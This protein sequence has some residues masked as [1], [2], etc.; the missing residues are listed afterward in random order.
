MV[1]L[2]DPLIWVLLLPA[3]AAS[4]VLVQMVLGLFTCCGTF[5]LRGRSVPLRWW[6]IPLGAAI[7]GLLWTAVVLYTLLSPQGRA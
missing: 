5:R 2:G 1:R 3:L 4:G 6:S 7:T